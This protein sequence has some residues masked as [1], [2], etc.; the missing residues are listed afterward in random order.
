MKQK[1]QMFG[2]WFWVDQVWAVELLHIT[3]QKSFLDF[4]NAITTMYIF[5][6]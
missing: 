6:S 3:L 4:G 2:S 1:W 5:I